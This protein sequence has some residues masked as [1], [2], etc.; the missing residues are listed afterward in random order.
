MKILFHEVTFD[1]PLLATKTHC[2]YNNL[3]LITPANEL[4]QGE[5]KLTINIFHLNK[6]NSQAMK[7]SKKPPSF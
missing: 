4:L 6:G 1:V 3:M 7:S 5:Q 2:T